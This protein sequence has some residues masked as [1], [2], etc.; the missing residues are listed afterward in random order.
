MKSP[1][2]VRVTIAL[3]AAALIGFSQTAG[4]HAFLDHAS[5]RVGSVVHGSPAEVKVWFTEELEPAFSSLQV[6]DQ[7]GKEIDRK[8]KQ[9]D[10]SDRTAIRVSVPRLAPGMYQVKWRALS[11]DTH[12]TEGDFKF[13]VAP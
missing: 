11:V 2:K 9:L 7:G 1:V 12:V 13:E 10:S 8:D 6:F 4:A 3:A 5:P